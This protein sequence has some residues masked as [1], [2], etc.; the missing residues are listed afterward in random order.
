MNGGEGQ[1]QEEVEEEENTVEGPG[2]QVE[3]MDECVVYQD[4]LCQQRC[5]NTPGSYRCECFA[6]F[7]LQ[8]DGVTCAPGKTKTLLVPQY[9]AYTVYTVMFVTD[10]YP[11]INEQ[12]AFVRVTL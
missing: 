9:D 7:L 1:Q 8:Q 11:T 10:A 3:D 12:R 4:R 2:Y 5:V 6:G